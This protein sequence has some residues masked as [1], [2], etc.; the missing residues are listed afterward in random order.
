MALTFL[1]KNEFIESE[2]AIAIC[3]KYLGKD[4]IHVG[5]ALKEDEAMVIYFSHGEEIPYESLALQDFD[6]YL[7]APIID[8]NNDL[9]PSLSAL[10]E[11]I[12]SDPLVNKLQFSR[13]NIIYDGGKFNLM[14]GVF[15]INSMIENIVNCGIF[16]TALLK[17]YDYNLLE[18]NTWPNSRPQSISPYLDIW[19]S[20][21]ISDADREKYYNTSKEI[22]GKH[23][24]VSPLT[25]SKPSVYLETEDLANSL[26]KELSE[27]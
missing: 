2:N 17:T 1:T 16:A 12:S 7:F 13:S 18:W 25:Q 19:L 20:S 14:S 5:I 23:V 6:N 11:V 10:C 21:N 4:A 27:C 8:F 3:G 9:I 22:R 26:I 15:Q 24:I